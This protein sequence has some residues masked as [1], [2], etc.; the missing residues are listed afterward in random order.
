MFR[1]KLVSVSGGQLG[2]PSLSFAGLESTRGHSKT[3]YEQVRQLTPYVYAVGRTSGGQ[4][5][6]V[7]VW[8]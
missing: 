2:M 4:H 3:S 5:F 7:A 6:F 1:Q 8:V